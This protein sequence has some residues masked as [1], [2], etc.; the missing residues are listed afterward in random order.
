MEI[1]VL[2]RIVSINF[3]GRSNTPAPDL[4]RGSGADGSLTC[5]FSWFGCELLF[6]PVSPERAMSL[7]S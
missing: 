2:N 6:M 3:H 7:G 1:V 5:T 4:S